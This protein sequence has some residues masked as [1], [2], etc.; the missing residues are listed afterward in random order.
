MSTSEK[1]IQ[2]RRIQ[3]DARVRMLTKYVDGPARIIFRDHYARRQVIVASKIVNVATPINPYLAPQL[4]FNDY[5]GRWR[6]LSTSA[7]LEVQFMGE[8]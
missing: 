7:I 3:R 5:M 2:I 4:V 6:V 8:H 1:R